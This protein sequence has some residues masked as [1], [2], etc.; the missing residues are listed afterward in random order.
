MIRYYYTNIAS[1]YIYTFDDNP[2]RNTFYLNEQYATI[3]LTFNAIKIRNGKG[4]V[5]KYNIA[6]SITGLLYKKNNDTQELLNTTSMLHERVPL[7]QN[8]TKHIYSL[9][10]PEKWTL[11]FENIPREDNF[12]YDLQVQINSI[13]SRNI[14]NE[15]FLIFTTE[16]DLSD[17]K[18][19]KQ[20]DYTWIIVG[21]ILGVIVAIVIA[22]F[23]FKY[24]RL[25]KSNI[26]LKEEMKSMAYSND[27]QKNVI[28][29][30]RKNSERDGDYESTFI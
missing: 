1:E 20:K 4:P 15:E 23:I 29:K 30:E 8:Q 24:I 13:I 3:S 12:V 19:E 17:I 7:H 18:P 22:F 26:N 2:E 6:F 14:F 27:V 10:N 5:N 28:N 9:N 21:I 25:Q 16:I 11:T